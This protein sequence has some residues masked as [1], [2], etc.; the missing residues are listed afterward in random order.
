MPAKDMAGY[1]RAR[2]ARQRAER[3]AAASREPRVDAA[4]PRNA[5]MSAS[6]TE[7]A[8]VRAKLAT[9]GPGAVITRTGGRLDDKMH[10]RREIGRQRRR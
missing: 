7:L 5:I 10:S 4:L 8:P 2:R 3:E 9:I 1:M 6:E